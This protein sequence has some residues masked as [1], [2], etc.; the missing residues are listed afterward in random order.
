MYI[1]EILLSL[2]LLV[3]ILIFLIVYSNRTNITEFSEI[4][5]NVNEVRI[6]LGKLE[7]LIENS[8]LNNE[9]RPTFDGDDLYKI[10]IDVSDIKDKIEEIH[11][12]EIE[13]LKSYLFNI[14]K[15][16]GEIEGQLSDMRLNMNRGDDNSWDDLPEV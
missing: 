3:L 13:G 9:S 15:E 12:N 10:R 7:D 2:I 11:K 5:H 14:E 8:N 1:T 16:L 4:H 6:S